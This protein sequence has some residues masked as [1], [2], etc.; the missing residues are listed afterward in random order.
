M[1]ALLLLPM[2]A[3]LAAAPALTRA[4]PPPPLPP[5]ETE[6]EMIEAEMLPLCSDTWQG[7]GG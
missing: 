6:A 4:P 7:C 5:L 1:R 2:V 3:A